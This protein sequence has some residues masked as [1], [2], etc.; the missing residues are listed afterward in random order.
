MTCSWLR[1]ALDLLKR[2][3]LGRRYSRWLCSVEA[4]PILFKE[5]LP[6]QPDLNNPG[7]LEALNCLPVDRAFKSYA[8][9]SGTGGPLPTGVTGAYRTRYS[10]RLYAAGM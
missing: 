9:L 8:P 4:Q 1:I 2:M 6:D 3:V 5:F 7:L 10:G